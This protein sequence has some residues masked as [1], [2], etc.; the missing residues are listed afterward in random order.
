MTLSDNILLS[1]VEG[2]T[3]FL[4]ISST[5]HLALT[6]KLLGLEQNDFIKSFEIFIQFGAILAVVYLYWGKIVKN[7]KLFYKILTAFIPTGVIGLLLYK[8]IKGYLLENYYIMVWTLLIGG[9]LM[10]IMELYNIRTQRHQIES[11]EKMSYTQCVLIGI[12][13]SLAVV[14]GVSRAAA[15]I[16]GGQTFGISRKAIVE[17]SF[18]LA[19]PTMLFATV[20]DISKNVDIID[21]VNITNMI[22]GMVISF[23][24]A[25]ISVKFLLR[26]IQRNNFIS[27]G[28]YRIVIAIMFLWLVL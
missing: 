24:V 28:V 23:F 10:I 13:Q 17:F 4:P 7:K 22:I 18:L 19:V 16:I 26:F 6:S 27:F 5:A 1:I 2:I 3:E 21:R 9:V 14:P 8:I 11:I 25:I 12:A 15:T 20:Y